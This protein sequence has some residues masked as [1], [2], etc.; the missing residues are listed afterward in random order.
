MKSIFTLLLTIAFSI[1]AIANVSNSEKSILLKLYKATN[2]SHWNVKWDLNAPVTTW[3][4]VKIKNGNVV[5][6]NLSNNNLVGNLP[7]EITDLKNLVEL[8]LF[9]NEISG[10][11]PENIGKLQELEKLNL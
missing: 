4:G 8:D 2:G 7:K 3:Q 1:C 11:I 5:G 9:K 10:T 6:L